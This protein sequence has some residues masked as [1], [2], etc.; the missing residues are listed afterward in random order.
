[1]H[2]LSYRPIPFATLFT[3]LSL[4]SLFT[5]PF[6]ILLQHS[7]IS[8]HVAASFASWS[9]SS[10]P[11]CPACALIQF[12][13]VVHL[14]FSNSITL[15]LICSIR[16]VWFFRFFSDSNAI[17]LSVNICT[18][19]SSLSKY[20]M[21]SLA[22]NVASSSAWLFEHR[23]SNLYLYVSVILSSLNITIPDPTPRSLL[24]PS[25]YMNVVFSVFWTV[26]SFNS[27]VVNFNCICGV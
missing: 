1:L 13:S 16:C 10:F 5:V 23:P 26:S 12:N 22:F 6:G 19:L 20:C 21:F 7:L 27:G 9:A 18:V 15:F 3:L 25:V 24:M 11:W 8:L 17:R 2:L 4:N 14:W